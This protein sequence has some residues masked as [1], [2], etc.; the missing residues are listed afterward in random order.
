MAQ[1]IGTPE[2]A[3]SKVVSPL[4]ARVARQAPVASNKLHAII[5]GRIPSR[6]IFISDLL[7]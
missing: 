6:V 2:V 1:Q 7:R 5:R 4:W 3:Y